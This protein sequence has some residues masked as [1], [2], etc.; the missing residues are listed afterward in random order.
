M[1]R[2]EIAEIVY[3]E[4]PYYQNLN[5][6]DI[7][8][9]D[10]NPVLSKRE[11]IKNLGRLINPKYW[12]MQIRGQLLQGSTSGSTGEILSVY[13]DRSDFMRSLLPLW[14]YRRK[15]YGILPNDKLVYFYSIRETSY[16]EIEIN[17][18][19][20]QIGFCKSGLNESKL[21]EIYKKI[22]SFEPVWMLIQPSI[23]AL[24]ADVKKKYNLPQIE[25]LRYIECSGEIL[26]DMVI[27]KLKMAFSCIIANQYGANE[28]GS[29]AYQCEQG[30]LHIMDTNVY[31]E[32]V[33]DCN[34]RLKDGEEG[35]ICVTSLQ[36]T[37]MPLLRYDIGDRGILQE[38]NCQCGR[39]GKILQLTSGR[40]CDFI[41]L[42][43]GEKVSPFIFVR[44]LENINSS[45]DNIVQQF[46][47]I[48]KDYDRFLIKI[49]LEE[50]FQEHSLLEDK[51]F[52]TLEHIELRQCLYDFVYSTDFFWS[53]NSEKL[54]YFI[55]EL[56]F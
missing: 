34:N 54:R 53:G 12:A 23:A 24:L 40:S 56:P 39:R 51:F 33:D 18:T 30:H 21:L 36:N 25:S 11:A 17:H 55:S 2:Y 15:Q 1:N 14:I 27:S 29:I 45:F 6:V 16:P 41:L 22:I 5:R 50:D 47:I 49:S 26:Q 42:K 10:F 43:S 8:S 3:N 44:C 52:S 31:V 35:K 48:Q 4:I 28:V 46:Q 7:S 37:V 19:R 13:W 9:W 32:I 38:M 20:T